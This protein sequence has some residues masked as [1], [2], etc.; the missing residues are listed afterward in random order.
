MKRLAENVFVVNKVMLNF[1]MCFVICIAI[2]SNLFVKYNVFNW[3][4]EFHMIFCDAFYNFMPKDKYFETY[5]KCSKCD[6]FGS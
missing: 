6:I 5:K 2:Y 4:K 1:Y 3:K